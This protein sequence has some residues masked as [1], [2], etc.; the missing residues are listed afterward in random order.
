MLVIVLC[1]SYNGFHFGLLIKHRSIVV[2]IPGTRSGPG[3]D[4]W[5]VVSEKKINTK[6]SHT[7]TSP[8]IGSVHGVI[9]LFVTTIRCPFFTTNS[10]GRETLLST[11]LSTTIH[12]KSY[13]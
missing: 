11:V 9:V 8:V 7:K 5:G 1:L 12:G 3:F 13:V 6:R 10:F 4:P 2:I